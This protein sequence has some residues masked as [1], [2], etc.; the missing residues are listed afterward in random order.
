MDDS[1]L[2]ESFFERDECALAELEKNY[3]KIY[4][5]IINNV[6]CDPR[7][8]EECINDTLFTVWN[9]IPPTHPKSLLGFVI[10]IARTNAIDKLRYNTR[11]KRDEKH[12]ILLEEI[13]QLAASNDTPDQNCME[14]INEFLEKLPVRTRVVFLRRY[15]YL[16]SVSSIAKRFE[17]SENAVSAL[18]FRTREKLKRDLEKKGIIR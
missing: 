2:I 8:V 5:A 10:R 4:R 16:E 3:G 11:E 12:L 1:K 7:D 15:F 9:S 13:E 14:E 18:L 6:L 17:M